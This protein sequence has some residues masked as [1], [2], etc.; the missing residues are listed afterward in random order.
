MGLSVGDYVLATKY[1]DG[2]AN[3]PWGVGVI[4]QI[5]LHSS[6]KEFGLCSE[7]YQIKD[8]PH[9]RNEYRR[10]KKISKEFGDW[11]CANIKRI[12]NGGRTLWSLEREYTRKAKKGES[13]VD[14]KGVGWE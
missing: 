7:R 9:K 3:D 12:E 4:E 5:R 10:A 6:A 1:Q 11:I 8:D 13:M 2:D 14:A